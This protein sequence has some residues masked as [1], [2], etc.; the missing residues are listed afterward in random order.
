[1]VHG[2]VKRRTRLKRYAQSV[3][4][5]YLILQM[6]SKLKR[7]A[8]KFLILGLEFFFC[9]CYF[10]YF[11]LHL[12][13]VAAQVFFSSC[14]KQGLLFVAVCRLFTAVASL[15]AERWS[16]CGSQ[17]QR[18]AQ[19]FWHTGLGALRHVGSS[20]SRDRTLYWQVDASPLIHQESL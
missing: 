7:V 17:L 15:A 3:F 10:I 5:E 14:S 16:S 2:V 20:G 11:W 12:V 13:L 19:Q 4:T 8:P 6:F 18:Q 9:V 1:M